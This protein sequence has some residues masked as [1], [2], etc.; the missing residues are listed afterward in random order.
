MGRGGQDQP[1][2]SIPNWTPL[3]S[4]HKSNNLTKQLLEDIPLFRVVKVLLVLCGAAAR[5][6]GRLQP[7]PVRR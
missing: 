7:E 2:P 1:Y 5:A 3:S 6:Q 4:G